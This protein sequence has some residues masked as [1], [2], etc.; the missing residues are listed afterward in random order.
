M[1]R[2]AAAATSYGSQHHMGT[3]AR[4]AQPTGQI[5]CGDRRAHV[6]PLSQVATQRYKSVPRFPVL[7]SFGNDLK[8]HVVTQLDDGTHYGCIRAVANHAD[9]EGLVDLDLVDR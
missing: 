8:T 2:S 7:H 9:D 5:G 1:V 3:P 4:L 6:I